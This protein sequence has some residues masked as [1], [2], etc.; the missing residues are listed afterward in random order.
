MTGAAHQTFYAQI[1]ANKRQSVLLAL[2]VAAL[3]GL[4]AFAIGYGVTGSSAAS[5]PIFAGVVILS[6]LVAVGTLYAGGGLVL[7]AAATRN[8]RRWPSQPACSTSSTARSCRASSATSSR[9]SETTTSASRCS[10]AF[11]WA[12]WPSSPTCSCASPS[13]AVAARVAAQAAG[14]GCR[15]SSSCSR[16]RWPSWRPSRRVWSSSP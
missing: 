6:L 1:A 2:I 3:L 11:W 8:T 12:A 15:P 5:V 10:S 14:E 13:G 16:S 9:T 4:L 7:A